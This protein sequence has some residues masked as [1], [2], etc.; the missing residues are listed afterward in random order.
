MFIVINTN[1]TDPM[2]GYY[3]C[4][5]A[6]VGLVVALDGLAGTQIDMVLLSC[7]VCTLLW[8][9]QVVSCGRR[10]LCGWSSH[11]RYDRSEYKQQE[12]L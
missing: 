2:R 11:K 5:R 8:P 6:L 12:K 9:A 4:G 7:N 10:K 3:S 1:N